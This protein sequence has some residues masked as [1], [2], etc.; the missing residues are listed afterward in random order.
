M[1]DR[2]QFQLDP[3]LSSDTYAL[4]TIIIYDDDMELV[5]HL[6]SGTKIRK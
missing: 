5:N 2:R 3:L 4:K 6:E 1:I